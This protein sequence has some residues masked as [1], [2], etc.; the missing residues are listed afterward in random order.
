MARILLEVQHVNKSARKGA[1]E[2]ILKVGGCCGALDW[3][4]THEFAIIWIENGS[5]SYF[6]KREGQA[7][8]IIIATSAEG[9][10]YL[11]TKTD[12]E[13]PDSLLCLPECP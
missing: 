8:G 2:R 10:K 7:V 12:G 3:R 13:Q 6:L 1:H 9:H 11:K 5:F 4:H